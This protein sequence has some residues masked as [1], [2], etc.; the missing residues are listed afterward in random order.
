MGVW[1]CTP[2][3]GKHE[4]R[5]CGRKVHGTFEELRKT[6]EEKAREGTGAS[7]NNEP[8]EAPNGGGGQTVQA[9]KL[10]CG[11]GSLHETFKMLSVD[12]VT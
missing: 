8:H 5:L 9:S 3:G 10:A 2:D 4:Q 6:A 7:G 12:C 1:N 11:D